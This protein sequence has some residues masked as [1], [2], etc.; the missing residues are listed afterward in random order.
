M[1]IMADTGAHP[2]RADGLH[3]S[4]GNVQVLTDVSIFLEPGR[5]TGLIGPNGAGKTSLFNCLTGLYRPKRGR[6]SFGDIQLEDLPPN[7]RA[8]LGISRSFQHMALSADLSV[9]E[10]V[11][12]GLTLSRTTGWVGAFLPLPASRTE[13]VAANRKAMSALASLGIASAAMMT[14][15]E[16]PPGTLRL[17]EIARAMVCE[18]RALLLDEPAAG[19]NAVETRDLMRALQRLIH[20]GLVVVVVEHDM[21]LI[22]QLCDQIYVLSAG[23]VIAYGSPQEVRRDPEVI[24]IYLG[25]PDD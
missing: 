6:I 21:D 11:M 9:L 14:P 20:P 10:N 12:V 1:T 16:L 24:R 8:N 18:P 3:L 5:I 13:S 15:A 25:D 19:L 23:R 2:L 7:R 17:V 22:M 4:F